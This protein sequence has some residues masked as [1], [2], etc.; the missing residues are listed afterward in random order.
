[1]I[2]VNYIGYRIRRQNIYF[3]AYILGEH[4]I[5]AYRLHSAKHLLDEITEQIE[6]LSYPGYLRR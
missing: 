3:E 1:M 2:K 6:V 5:L 4:D